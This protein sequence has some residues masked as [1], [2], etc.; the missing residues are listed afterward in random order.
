MYVNVQFKVYSGSMSANGYIKHLSGI[1]CIDSSITDIKCSLVLDLTAF[2]KTYTFSAQINT[3]HFGIYEP[4]IRD[5]NHLC[6][7]T[8]AYAY[9]FQFAF[10]YL[11][12]I[13]FQVWG[14]S[15]FVYIFNIVYRT[16]VRIRTNSAVADPEGVQG[17]RLS[18][19]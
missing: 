1:K 17:V 10:Y 14:I 16:P 5:L 6:H 11:R 12:A 18:P 3:S 2:R 15:H 4:D 8:T 19:S 7:V 9:C 13:L